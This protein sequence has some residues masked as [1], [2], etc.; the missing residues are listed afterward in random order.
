[1]WWKLA[2]LCKRVSRPSFWQ[3]TFWRNHWAALNFSNCQIDPWRLH[4]WV[5]FMMCNFCM[6]WTYTPPIKTKIFRT[7]ELKYGSTHRIQ[8]NVLHA[9]FFRG[10]KNMY[11]HSMSF[12]HIDVT[13]LDEIIGRTW[14]RGYRRRGYLDHAFMPQCTIFPSLRA[15]WGAVMHRWTQP[16]PQMHFRASLPIKPRLHYTR[17]EATFKYCSHYARHRRAPSRGSRAFGIRSK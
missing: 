3:Q 13:Q 8:I 5:C 1:M 15:Q 16:Q 4:W 11:L 17:R 12:L 2:T 6:R 14:R 7:F 9:K 10:N